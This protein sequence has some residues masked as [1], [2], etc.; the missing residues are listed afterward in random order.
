MPIGVPLQAAPAF[1]PDR[2]PIRP[3]D[4]V[5]Y[6]MLPATGEHLLDLRADPRT[7][8]RMDLR[9]VGLGRT[10]ESA[11]RVAVHALERGGPADGAVLDEPLERAHPAGFE[12][13]KMEREVLRK[14]FGF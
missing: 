11:R 5:L 1:H 7:V 14:R 8:V 13:K 6:V 3:D 10:R 12:G 9:K 2:S 4:T